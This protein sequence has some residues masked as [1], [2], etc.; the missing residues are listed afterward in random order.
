MQPSEPS[1]EDHDLYAGQY[2]FAEYD[3]VIVGAGPA[4]LATAIH[5]KQLAKLQNIE[6]SVVVLEKAS[7]V[8]AHILSGAIM[9]M[10]AMNELLPNWQQLKAPIQQTVTSDIFVFLHETGA[11]K[12]PNFLLPPNFHNEGNYIISLSQVTRWLADQAT[13]L[14]VDI[15]PGFAAS[16]IL[17]Q[18]GAVV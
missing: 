11:T 10:R 13:A 6:I 15:F 1:H 9:D 12:V 7:E 2:E 14:G 4:G 8:G 3:V 17:Y 18:N 16:Q 5:L